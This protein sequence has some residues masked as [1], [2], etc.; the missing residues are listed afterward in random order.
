MN[1]LIIISA[2]VILVGALILGAIFFFMPK[3]ETE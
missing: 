3:N 2:S 1:K